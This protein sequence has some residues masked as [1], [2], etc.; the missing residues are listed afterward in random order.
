MKVELEVV[1]YS[2]VIVH[3]LLL[4]L[5]VQNICRGGGGGK[6]PNFH[7]AHSLPPFHFHFWAQR[8]S[9]ALTLILC[10]SA[11]PVS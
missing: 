11:R 6:T 7:Q 3:Q 2:R 5:M 1:H 9:V 4:L 8:L 10:P